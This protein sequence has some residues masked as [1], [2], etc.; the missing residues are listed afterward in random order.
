MIERLRQQWQ[1][2]QQ[3]FSEQPRDRRL[4]ITIG[5]WALITL[6][7]LS[8]QLVPAL[9]EHQQQQQRRTQ[10]EQQLV[11]Q[12]QLRAQLTQQ[13]QTDVNQ[14]LQQ[15]IARKRERLNQVEANSENYILLDPEER[16][17]FLASSLDY[18]DTVELVSLKSNSPVAIGDER[19][20]ASLYQHQVSAVYRGSFSDL[21][22][23]FEK[24]RVEH[25]NVQWYQFH[26]HV[27]QYPQAEVQLTWQLLSVD[28]EIISG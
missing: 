13:L 1:Q 6:P 12:Q 4:L 24:L 23:F 20:Y 10:I 11:Q 14:P 22:R 5:L 18:P 16:R 26:Y 28:K 7:L 8:Y 19:D 21:K 9:K 2:L 25:P 15:K 27:V 3:R 17:Q